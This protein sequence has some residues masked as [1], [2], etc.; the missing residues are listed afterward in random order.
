MT[1]TVRPLISGLLRVLV[2]VAKPEVAQPQRPVIEHELGGA[3]ARR[4]VGFGVVTALRP[5]EAV[6]VGAVIGHEGE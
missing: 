2:G 6:D 4:G 3:G 5:G 1:S